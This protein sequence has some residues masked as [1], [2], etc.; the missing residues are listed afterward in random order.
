MRKPQTFCG[1][2][3]TIVWVIFSPKIKTLNRFTN[4][5]KMYAFG[6]K[7][8]GPLRLIRKKLIE[9]AIAL[10]IN[11]AAKYPIQARVEGKSP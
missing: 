9:S 6:A 8:T 3:S 2:A 11:D 4:I 7:N 10:E 5:A 1:H